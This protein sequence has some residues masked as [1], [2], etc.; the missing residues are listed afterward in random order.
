MML[1]VLLLL[2]FSYLVAN[3]KALSQ[4]DVEE[5]LNKFPWIR[6]VS[7]NQCSIYHVDYNNN[8]LV[9]LFTYTNHY[10]HIEKRDLFVSKRQW[11]YYTV[12]GYYFFKE[13]NKTLREPI[14]EINL[15]TFKQIE[16]RLNRKEKLCDIMS[17]LGK[18]TSTKSENND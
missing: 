9:K 4:L 12:I 16:E 2:L 11:I 1:T 5:E 8:K 7:E 6:V 13:F 17:L 14:K 15:L 3:I 10:I 18:S